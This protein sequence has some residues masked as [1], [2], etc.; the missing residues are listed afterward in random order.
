MDCLHIY[1][2]QKKCDLPFHQR[3]K[4]FSAQKGKYKELNFLEMS[5]FNNQAC[6]YGPLVPL[7]DCD[8][9]ERDGREIVTT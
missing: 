9:Q 7:L 3:P 5:G 6:W 1:T 4:L 8:N 2:P